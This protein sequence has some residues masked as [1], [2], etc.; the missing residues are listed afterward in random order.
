MS[1]S[2]TALMTRCRRAGRVARRWLLVV[3]LGLGAES[4]MA[5]PPPMLVIA[6][7]QVREVAAGQRYLVQVRSSAPQSFDVLPGSPGIVLVRLHGARLGSAGDV[8]AADFGTLTLQ[9]E[10]GGS[11]LL[12]I[13]LA[14][15]S[16]RV[17]VGQGGNPSTVEI[18]VSR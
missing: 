3:L 12:R 14:D 15:T 1:A 2:R 5:A 9:D 6:D 10:A 17:T 13:E 11:V 18:R 4:A 7:V 8:E 16:Y